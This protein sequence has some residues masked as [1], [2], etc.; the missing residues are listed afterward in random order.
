MFYR[1]PFLFH[2][3]WY[4]V[5]YHFLFY[6]LYYD[7][8]SKDLI[9]PRQSTLHEHVQYVFYVSYIFTIASINRSLHPLF[10]KTYLRSIKRGKR[11]MILKRR[12]IRVITSQNM[13]F[14]KFALN[15]HY[16]SKSI[17]INRECDSLASYTISRGPTIHVTRR[18]DAVIAI[19]IGW[20]CAR[21]TMHANEEFNGTFPRAATPAIDLLILRSFSYVYSYS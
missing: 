15:V 6:F 11:L 1:I 17:F 19:N 14:M 20:Q 9:P 4:T 16:K 7:V 3:I 10:C 18:T 13:W 8:S 21:V 12:S 5:A 2:V